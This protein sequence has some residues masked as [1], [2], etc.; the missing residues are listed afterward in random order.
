MK[1][2]NPDFTTDWAWEEW[3]KRDPYFGVITDP[4]FRR[5]E[6]TAEVRHEFFESGANHL[7]LIFETV[8]RQIAADFRPKR[9]LEFGC[10]VGRVLLPLAET[11]EHVVGLDVS[12]S[13]L[14]EARRNCDER[15][16]SN[17]SLL[18]SDDA[19]SGLEGSFD[20]IHSCIVF[21]HIPEERG[22]VIF[23]NLL[24]R[25]DAGG[26]GAIQLTYSKTQFAATAGLPPPV[27][28]N[29]AV[30]G[31]RKRFAALRREPPKPIN[32]DPEIQMNPYNLNSILFSMQTNSI[33][34]FFCDF[35]NHGGE[36]G[37][38]CYFQ[39]S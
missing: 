27:E 15:G 31:S 32:A 21:Q 18:R 2:L 4:K 13:M 7:R 19:L 12:Q 8:H 14:D 37:V 16:L 28:V 20:F 1:A 25:L 30:T 35:T 29:T 24:R 33:N 36:L 5:K 23:E 26:V 6:M 34:R 22:R 10:G 38:Y 39:K 9:A 17:V 3:G 11:T